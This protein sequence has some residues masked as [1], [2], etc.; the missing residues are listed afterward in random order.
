VAKRLR[1]NKGKVVSS[2]TRNPKRAVSDV[3]KVPSKVENPKTRNKTAGVGPKKDWSKVKVKSTAGRT[4]KRKVASTSESEYDV[5]KDAINIIPTSVLS[6]N[7]SI[8]SF[9]PLCTK[10]LKSTQ[11]EVL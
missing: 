5:E 10:S 11:C 8:P 9:I 2:K 1:S 7:F 4:M 3:P 6:P